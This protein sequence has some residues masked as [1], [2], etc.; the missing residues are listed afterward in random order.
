LPFGED[1][2]LTGSDAGGTA[3][4]RWQDDEYVTTGKLRAHALTTA[5]RSHALPDIPIMGDFV[6]RYET[7][8]WCGIRAARN[9]AAEIVEKLA[10]ARQGIDPQGAAKLDQERGRIAASTG[11]PTLSR[12]S[13]SGLVSRVT[14]VHTAVRNCTRDEGRSFEVGNQV[15]ISRQRLIRQYV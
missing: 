2:K 7:S 12:T 6:P 8:Q 11:R 5:M 3:G 10:A 9:T 15:L 14:P 1:L 4:G 13:A